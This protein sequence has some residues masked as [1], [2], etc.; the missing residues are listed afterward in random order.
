LVPP[1]APRN[2]S[3]ISAANIKP[4]RL[5]VATK[6]LLRVIFVSPFPAKAGLYV[7]SAAIFLAARGDMNNAARKKRLRLELLHLLENK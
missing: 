2:T 7:R 5:S 1:H 3:V 6:S 4:T